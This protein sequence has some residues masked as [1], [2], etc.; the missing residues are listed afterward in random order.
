MNHKK[1]R[2][3]SLML[4]FLM[5]FTMM[6][7][8]MSPVTALAADQDIVILYTNDVH[9]AVDDNLGYAGLS[10][11]KKE[12]QKT[13]PYVTLV[14]AGDSIQGAPIGTLSEGE[15]I[16]D[17]M[18]Q[19]GYDFAVPGNHEFDFKVPRLLELNQKLN[20]H[21]TSCN[22]M[23]LTRNTTVFQPYKI[24]TYGDTDVAF[25]G[26]TT[27]ESFTKSTPA[28]FQDA[29]GNYIYGFCED[30][31][32]SALYQKIQS[33]VDAAIAEGADY[34]VLVA[35]LGTNGS[36]ERWSAPAVIKNLSNVDAVI[37]GHSHETY[38]QELTDKDGQTVLLAQTGTKLAQ[39]G[40]LT[41]KPDGTM[42]NELVS[43][44][45]APEGL[46]STYV[47]QPG[48]SLSRISKR[49]LGSQKRWGEI[50]NLNRDRIQN[51]NMI[52][53]GLTLQ[54]PGTAITS[55]AGVPQDPDTATF[56]ET[57]KKQFEA[58]LETVVGHTDVELTINDPA[59]GKRAVRSA[60][61]NLGDLSADA[62]RTI[63]GAQIGL[64]NGG[65]CR[66]SIDAGDI[67]YGDALTV[68]PFGNSVCLIEASGQQIK[69][70]LE[71][72]SRLAPE[73]NG[74]FLQVSGLSYTIDTSVPS[75]VELDEKGNFVKVN[76][77]YRVSDILVDGQ[78]LDLNKTYTVASHNYMLLEAGDGMSMFKG[79]NVLKKDIAV[80]VDALYTYINQTL[81]GNV[82]GDYANPAGSGR[83]TIQ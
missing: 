76:G 42:T 66:A 44:I 23:D 31:T 60:E 29:S 35:H 34:V 52:S 69:D 27:P 81:G 64:A 16:I 40:K 21:Y 74:G 43:Q 39:I 45:P 72:G 56:I 32:G 6:L 15:Y 57:I 83:I 48:D 25:V 49:V 63:A 17:I 47:V 65:G 73:E 67:T 51:P 12:M 22:F 11:Y 14:D 70:A 18:N 24:F 41:I 19:V 62:Y 79:C 82:G 7:S 59:T 46:S 55:E 36:T 54:I 68:F 33:S 8:G 30:E 50:Y 1:R 37:D 4:A 77:A 26:A 71:M 28:Y 2:F 75:S 3:S 10:L 80:D 38:S 5:V 78:P 58:T 61:T 20:C 53:V 9:C 13:T